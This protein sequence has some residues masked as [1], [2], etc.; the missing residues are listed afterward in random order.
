[1]NYRFH[2]LQRNDLVVFKA[3]LQLEA[4]NLHDDLIERVVGLPGNVVQIHDGKALI[5]GKVISEPFVK[6]KAIYNYGS[7][8]VPQ[9]QYFV[10]GDNRNHS[11]DSHLWGLVS[12]QTIIE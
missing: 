7:V 5:N 9:H 4:Q 1:M 11:Y 2:P 10:L 3:P 8:S 6:E 12:E